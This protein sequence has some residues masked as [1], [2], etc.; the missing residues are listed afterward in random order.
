MPVETPLGSSSVGPPGQATRNARISSGLRQARV[1]WNGPWRF[2]GRSR[3][4]RVRE[5]LPG[6]FEEVQVPPHP[7]PQAA[8]EGRPHHPAEVLRL[9]HHHRV[10]APSKSLRRVEQDLGEHVSYPPGA[11]SA[12]AI[13]ASRPASA[14][15][16]RAD[17]VEVP[18]G[19]TGQVPRPSGEEAAERRVEADEQRVESLGRE[20]AG[21]F[22][23]EEGLARPGPPQT[24]ARGT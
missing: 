16:V 14:A 22:D 6:V 20:T 1:R 19:E 5:R 18:G 2:A 8:L 15:S 23:G 10:I 7:L 12:A 13:R 4:A 11:A 17:S 9:V 24:C 21:R 3:G